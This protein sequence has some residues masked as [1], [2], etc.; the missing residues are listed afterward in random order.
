M[1]GCQRWRTVAP[2]IEERAGILRVPTLAPLKSASTATRA[3]KAATCA[4][5][6]IPIAK[7]TRRERAAEPRPAPA[8]GELPHRRGRRLRH[9]HAC[10]RPR[11]LARGAPRRTRRLS[12]GEHAQ[13]LPGALARQGGPVGATSGGVGGR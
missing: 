7:R 12:R 4:T 10:V 11:G 1:P 13:L 8:A 9:A 5:W 3:A 6:I 2:L